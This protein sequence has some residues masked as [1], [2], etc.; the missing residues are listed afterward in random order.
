MSETLR[1][2]AFLAFAIS[3]A[4]GVALSAQDYLESHKRRRCDEYA[5]RGEQARQAAQENL[6]SR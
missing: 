4:V 3:L 6:E 2:L 5:A 1:L